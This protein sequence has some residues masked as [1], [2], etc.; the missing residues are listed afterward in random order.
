MHKL[1]EGIQQF[2]DHLFSSQRERFERLA[3]GQHLEASFITSGSDPLI[4]PKIDRE[5]PTCR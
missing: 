2:Q 1:V 4:E 3:D 5:K